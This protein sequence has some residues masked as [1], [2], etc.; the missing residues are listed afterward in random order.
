RRET[1][2]LRLPERGR[3]ERLLP[4]LRSL[5]RR[6]LDQ[7]LLFRLRAGGGADQ[8]DGRHSVGGLQPGAA[9]L[10]WTSERGSILRSALACAAAGGAVGAAREAG[11]GAR[12]RGAGGAVRGAGRQ[13]RRPGPAS[14]PALEAGPG[15]LRQCAAAGGRR[16]AGAGWGARA[17][18]RRAGRTVRF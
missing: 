17:A 3:E 6:R 2:G 18:Q 4:A 14:R 10:V 1:D 15:R 5:V 11:A 12:E 13:S 9:A 8:A 16:R 7:L